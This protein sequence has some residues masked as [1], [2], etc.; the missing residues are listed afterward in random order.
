MT[1]AEWPQQAITRRVGHGTVGGVCN[2]LT[3]RA[4]H[5]PRLV[6]E[7]AK[8]AGNTLIVHQMRSRPGDMQASDWC[9]RKGIE[10]HGVALGKTYKTKKQGRVKWRRGKRDGS[11]NRQ[12]SQRIRSCENFQPLAHVIESAGAVQFCSPPGHNGG[13]LP[14]A[15]SLPPLPASPAHHR[16]VS[17]NDRRGSPTLLPVTE[18]AFFRTRG[19]AL[20]SLS[21][22]VVSNCTRPDAPS[23]DTFRIATSSASLSTDPSA[24]TPTL[25][26]AIAA[27]HTP[28][29]MKPQ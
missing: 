12:G 18:R 9:V 7:S 10:P 16:H 19:I 21:P 24:P 14:C 8:R 15:S 25:A 6:G 20:A 29:Y 26:S 17:T 1:A 13:S 3:S 11:P 5:C 23:N 4:R 27:V 28:S 2:D 22:D